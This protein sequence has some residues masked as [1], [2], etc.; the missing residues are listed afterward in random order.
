MILFLGKTGSVWLRM[1]NC[2]YGNCFLLPTLREAS[3]N[4]GGVITCRCTLFA[5]GLAHHYIVSNLLR[6]LWV[7]APP[8]C[9]SNTVCWVPSSDNYLLNPALSGPC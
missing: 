1:Q 4:R 9:S 2:N 6:T 8:L 7:V 5:Q 3:R